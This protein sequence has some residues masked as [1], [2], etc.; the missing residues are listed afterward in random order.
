[1]SENKTKFI[2]NDKTDISSLGICILEIIGTKIPNY[3]NP[4]KH[5]DII[6][7]KASELNKDVEAHLDQ[8]NIPSEKEIR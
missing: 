7:T 2:Y 4:E 3:K 8:C 1:M 6:F 5:L